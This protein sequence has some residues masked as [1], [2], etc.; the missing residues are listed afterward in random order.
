M[1]FDVRRLTLL[2]LSAMVVT[3]IGA[4]PLHADTAESAES[5]RVVTK[6]FSGKAKEPSAEHLVLFHNDLVYD[7][8]Q[9]NDGQ[10]TVYD[11]KRDRVILLDRATQVR[12]TSTTD[13]LLQ[14]T[15]KLRASALTAKNRQQLGIDATVNRSEDLSQYT[16]VYGSLSYIT[17]T[18]LPVRKSIAEQ[19]GRFADLASQLNIARA[20]GMP[21]IGRMTMYRQIADDGRVPTQTIL[22]IA[23]PGGDERFNSTNELIERISQ[24]DRNLIDEVGGMLA[25]Y[26]EVSLREFPE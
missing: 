3:H 25:L 26:R 23:Q 21:P 15:A 20:V 16:I 7:L 8:P 13:E 12:A 19:Y 1:N 14:L 9:T 17:T 6:I 24:A 4:L 2:L 10:I 5:F 22:T 11:L 18:Q